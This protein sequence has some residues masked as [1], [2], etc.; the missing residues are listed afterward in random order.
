L[1]RKSIVDEPAGIHG[2]WL[3][4][5]IQVVCQ[6]DVLGE[7]LN[8]NGLGNFSQ[9]AEVGLQADSRAHSLKNQP[10]RHR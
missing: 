4:C 7:L 6:R 10:R 9:W 3:H 2:G 5:N 8:I 1:L